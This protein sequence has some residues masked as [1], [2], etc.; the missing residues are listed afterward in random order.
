MLLLLIE[1]KASETLL[2]DFR[3][4]FAQVLGGAQAKGSEIGSRQ[5]WDS[6]QSS[7]GLCDKGLHHQRTLWLPHILVQF[8]TLTIKFHAEK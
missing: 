7:P 6:S 4:L 2:Q 5:V 1:L 8:G 3:D